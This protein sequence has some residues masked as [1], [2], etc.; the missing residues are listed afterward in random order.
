M[1]GYRF[2][3]SDKDRRLL[4]NSFALYLAPDVI[5]RML[6]SNKLPELGELVSRISRFD[7]AL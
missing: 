4:A 3:V 1:G 2:I 7:T 5:D 6:K